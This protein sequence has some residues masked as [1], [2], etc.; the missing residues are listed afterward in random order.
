[1]RKTLILCL[2]CAGCAGKTPPPE[3]VVKVKEVNVLVPVPCKTF[4]ALG[5]EP[6]YPDTDAKLFRAPDI[7]AMVRMLIMGRTMRDIRLK[8]YQVAKG[9]CL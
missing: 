2:L 9:R 6:M 8:E 5:D 4:E 7:E 3:P 1:M